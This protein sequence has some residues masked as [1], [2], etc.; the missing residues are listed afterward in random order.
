M[1]AD[2]ATNVLYGFDVRINKIIAI[3]IPIETMVK[4]MASVLRKERF[5]G[6]FST[7]DLALLQA[8]L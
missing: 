8:L 6:S 3:A 7:T 5:G 4:P 1:Q 2:S